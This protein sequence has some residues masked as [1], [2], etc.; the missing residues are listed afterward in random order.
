MKIS[1]AIEHIYTGRPTTVNHEGKTLRSSLFSRDEKNTVSVNFE[2][3]EGN[4]LA[5]A[6]MHGGLDRIAY[7]YSKEYYENWRKR[8]SDLQFVPGILGE[9]LLTESAISENKVFLGDQFRVGTA[10]FSVSGPRL[11]CN[12]LGVKMKSQ[13][14]VHE[15]MLKGETGFYLRLEKEG[16]IRKGDQ[17]ERIA[18]NNR[19]LSVLDI[20]KLFTEENVNVKT[21]QLV[22]ASMHLASDLKRNILDRYQA[23]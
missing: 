14:F 22:R 17:L 2:S 10:Y 13:A 3:I 5:D 16:V 18:S 1:H 23:A 9:N 12:K 4:H 15:F 7:L 21:L 8:R 6:N 19:E 11:P 20:T